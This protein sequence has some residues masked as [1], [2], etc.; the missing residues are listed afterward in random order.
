MIDSL[1]FGI[2]ALAFLV[3]SGLAIAVIWVWNNRLSPRARALSKRINEITLETYDLTHP[4]AA[5]N[6]S[7]ESD[8]LDWFVRKFPH[9]DAL[10]M[11]I[12]RAGETKTPFYIISLCGFIFLLTLAVLLVSQFS[13]IFAV[14]LGLM[15][16]SLPLLNLMFKEHKRAIKFEEQLPEALDFIA[17][18]LKAGHGI[19]SAISMVGEELPNPVGPEFKV[20][21]DQINFGLSFNDALANLASRVRSG[22]LNFLVTSLVIQRDTGGNLSELLGLISKTIR[23]RLKLKGKVRVLASEGKTSGVVL[24]SLPFVLGFL[25][26]LIN[27]DYVARLWH[28]PTGISMLTASFI[29]IPLGILWMWKIVQIKV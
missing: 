27:P 17:R 20:T 6:A 9:H 15:A 26:Y 22:D 2:P 1:I 16:A 10:Q 28:T 4:K 25:L 18:A 29:M 3:V 11:L 7:K 8:F 13:F 12:V 19:S 21:S 23:E 14:V 24:T 5:D